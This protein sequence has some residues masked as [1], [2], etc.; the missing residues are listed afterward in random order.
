MEPGPADG[1]RRGWR[2]GRSVTIGHKDNNLKGTQTE[3]N[4]MAAFAGESQARTRYNLFA[5]KARQQGLPE[6]AE[7]FD[8]TSGDEFEHATRFA[9]LLGLIKSTKTNL[10]TAAAG[11]HGEWTQIYPT[12]AAI[13]EREGFPEVAEAFLET[14]KE[15]RFHEKEFEELLCE[16]LGSD[17]K[18]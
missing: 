6:V 15:E 12:F 10:Q 16:L 11:E 1:R 13:A 8:E 14:A 18:H 4:L 17:K 7:E 3:A 5:E 2:E 9:E